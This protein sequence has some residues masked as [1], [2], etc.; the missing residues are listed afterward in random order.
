MHRRRQASI[1]A[2]ALGATVIEK[3]VT[4]SRADGGVDSDF[5]L[6]AFAGLV[7][8]D[9]ADVLGNFV[10][11]VLTM[12]T[13]NFEGKVFEYPEAGQRQPVPANDELE[14]VGLWTD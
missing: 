12:V 13:R 9:L 2:V 10:N 14:S 3:H 7:N 5:S 1:A 11:R 8:K 6:E 4:L